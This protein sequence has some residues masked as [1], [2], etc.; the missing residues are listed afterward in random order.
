M[1]DFVSLHNHTSFSIGRSISDPFKL[2]K[3]AKELGQKSIGICDYDTMAGMWDLLKA[4]KKV[5][6]PFIPGCYVNFVNDVN[7]LSDTR[8]YNIVLLAKTYKGYQNLLELRR[9]G[10]ENYLVD[11][12]KSSSRIDWNSFNNVEGIVCLSGA[13]TGYISQLIMQD[14]FDEALKAAER[15][16]SIFGSNFYLE[17]VSNNYQQKANRMIGMID[18]RKINLAKKK[19]ADQLGISAVVTTN[20]HYI[21]KE[22]HDDNDVLM[23]ISAKQPIFSGQRPRFDKPELFVQS[24]EQV[25]EYFNRHKNMW[26][27][28]F[29]HSLFANSVRIADECEFPDWVDPKFSNPSG[30][31]LPDFPVKDQKDYQDFLK[32]IETSPYKSGIEDKDYLRY[33]VEVAFQKKIDSGKISDIQL[34]R[35][36]IEEELDVLNYCGVNSYMLIVADYVQWARDN[37][38]SVGTGRGV[39][40]DYGT[41]NQ[42]NKPTHKSPSVKSFP[43]FRQA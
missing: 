38:I 29:I 39:I 23:S 35:D 37:N 16:R 32:W 36:R 21:Y 24:A 27:E 12:S 18:Q 11:K 13:G 6:I 34:Y 40:V 33:V 28:E 2:L 4:S 7:D 26:G 42:K 9:I 25:Y 14:K 19:I 30:K 5:G 3:R 31:E 41:G 10:F 15:F 17:L 22:E 20:S 43:D 1:I 8:L